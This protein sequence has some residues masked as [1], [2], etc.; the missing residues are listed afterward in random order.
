MGN[1]IK[2]PGVDQAF[3]YF[4]ALALVAVACVF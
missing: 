2:K 1:S 4:L 3:D